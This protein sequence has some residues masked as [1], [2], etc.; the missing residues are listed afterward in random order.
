MGGL[1]RGLG[2]YTR[3]YL[4]GKATGDEPGDLRPVEVESQRPHGRFLL[5]K[6]RGVDDPEAAKSLL[7]ASLFVDR[8]EMPPLEDGEYY[9]ADVLGSRVVDVEGRDLGRVVD[10]FATGAH[11][12]WVIDSGGREWMLPV[13]ESSVLAM[14][15]EGGEVRVEVP[16]G[17]WD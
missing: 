16:V 8:E 9:H 12:V 1:P 17:L 14:D 6:F 5:V 2:G 10:V 4:G 3:L 13:L 11:D 7:D 15:L